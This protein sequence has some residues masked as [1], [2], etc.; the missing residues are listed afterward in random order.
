VAMVYYGLSFNTKNIGGDIYVSNFISGF[1]EVVACVVIIPALAK[2]GRVK[3]YSGTFIIG[4]AACIA[5]ALILWVV[6]EGSLVWLI[7]TLAMTGK[8]LIAG[9]FALA[10]LYTAELF[11]TPVRNVAVGGA[12]T[13]AR[14]G[15]M[16]APYIVDIL[17]K[18]SAGVP[19][20]IFGISATLAGL[21]AMALPETL[22]KK[23]PE[24]VEDVEEYARRKKDKSKATDTEMGETAEK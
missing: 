5:V 20:L 4:G 21:F 22:N 11:P 7:I 6:E 1:A 17:G 12:S 15:S 18:Q 2:F 13:F 24:S 23:L 9:T 3:C 8:F 16:S 19:S 14:I 10:Y